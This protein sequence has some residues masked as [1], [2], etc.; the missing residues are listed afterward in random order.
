MYQVMHSCLQESTVKEK[1]TEFEMIRH[2][3]SSINAWIYYFSEKNNYSFIETSA[4]DSTNVTEAF[5]NLLVGK[6][7]ILFL[8]F[9]IFSDA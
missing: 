8:G 2:I 7:L 1:T 6:Y 5:N 9:E 4:L 3:R